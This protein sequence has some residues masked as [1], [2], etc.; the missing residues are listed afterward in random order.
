MQF[1]QVKN[2]LSYLDGIQKWQTN[3]SKKYNK[4]FVIMIVCKKFKSEITFTSKANHK[5]R[6]H[7]T[8]K[9]EMIQTL[10]F[11]VL[12]VNFPVASLKLANLLKFI[13]P[14]VQCATKKN[15]I[16][17]IISWINCSINRMLFN[18]ISQTIN[19]NW[20]ESSIFDM[21]FV[22]RKTTENQSDV[23]QNPSSAES[24]KGRK[25]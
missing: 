1:S 24:S 2:F 13:T 12:N 8:E 20:I 25:C 5:V 22:V 16:F 23:V 3:R 19:L 10:V 17:E 15:S 21:K 14:T 11:G 18:L 6:M 9:W 7:L 4:K